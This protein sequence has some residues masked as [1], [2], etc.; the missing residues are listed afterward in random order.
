M[1]LPIDEVVCGI[2]LKAFTSCYM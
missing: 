2:T 1:F